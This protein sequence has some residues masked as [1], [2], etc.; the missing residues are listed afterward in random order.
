MRG[1]IAAQE[2]TFLNK[3]LDCV[4]D[5]LWVKQLNMGHPEILADE[6]KKNDLK[7]III[8]IGSSGPTTKWGKKNYS[9][10]IK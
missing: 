8:G 3:Y 2:M 4:F 9:S 7:K 6:L 1:A 5:A 10:L